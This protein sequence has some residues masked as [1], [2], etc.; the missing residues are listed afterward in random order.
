MALDSSNLAHQGYKPTSYKKN[1]IEPSVNYWCQNYVD[2]Y[3]FSS[4]NEYLFFK[5]NS[6]R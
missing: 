6:K 4:R 3:F 5:I 2:M 1:G